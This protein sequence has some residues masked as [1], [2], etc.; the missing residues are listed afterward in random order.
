MVH[1]CGWTAVKV[2]E[3]SLYFAFDEVVGK[4]LV[5]VPLRISGLAWPFILLSEVCY[6]F[7]LAC[8]SNKLKERPFLIE[9]LG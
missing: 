1:W 7:H 9:G 8:Y 4:L 6:S 5:V 3:V 2:I